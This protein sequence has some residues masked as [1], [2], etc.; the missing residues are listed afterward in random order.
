[1]DRWAPTGARVAGCAAVNAPVSST[2]IFN[3]R[4]PVSSHQRH[5][6]GGAP[7]SVGRTAHGGPGRTPP[8][9]P[10]ANDRRVR[11][12]RRSDR[13][14]PARPATTARGADGS[15]PSTTRSTRACSAS[16]GSATER[17]ST[18]WTRGA[19]LPGQQDLHPNPPA[20]FAREPPDDVRRGVPRHRLVGITGER[21][22]ALAD[23]LERGPA[24]IERLVEVDV[25]RE[26]PSGEVRRPTRR[27]AVRHRRGPLRS[28][29]IP[30]R[31][32][33]GATSA[34]TSAFSA[35]AAGRDI[36]A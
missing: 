14:A 8:Q 28:H 27:A 29:P 10:G 6:H 16:E 31:V 7:V 22:V 15:A 30:P 32:R 3:S 2:T 13:P 12:R 4:R 19:S 35:S 21:S 1:M 5:R 24:A 11:G 36:G 25:E 17:T 26:Q 34:A 20:A 18:D 9:R 23:L 33:T